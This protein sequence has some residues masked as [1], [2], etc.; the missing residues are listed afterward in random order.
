MEPQAT[1][2]T[3]VSS[4]TGNS[5]RKITE[6]DAQA[7]QIEGLPF[8]LLANSTFHPLIYIS[9]LKQVWHYVLFN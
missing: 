1:S 8:K 2:P 5:K 9:I 6:I 7:V 4:Q 3:R